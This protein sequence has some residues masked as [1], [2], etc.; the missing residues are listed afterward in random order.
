MSGLR[1]A[2]LHSSPAVYT[3]V[4]IS[5]LPLYRRLLFPSLPQTTQPP[6]IFNHG[7]PELS[8]ATYE[9]LAVIL[10]SHVSPWYTRLT[11]DKT[12]IPE[13]T[14]AI[15]HGLRE[16][17]R[18]TL[19]ADLPLLVYTTLPALLAQHYTDYRAAQL[20]HALSPSTSVAECFHA[21]Q[22]H[23]ALTPESTVVNPEYLRQAV[24]FVLK[25]CMSKEDWEAET[26]R[27]I[28]R[29]VLVGPVLGGVLPRLAQPWFLFAMML[30][31]LGRGKG[32]KASA[33]S[34]S[35]APVTSMRQMLVLLIG[36]LHA[37]TSAL[38]SVV[39]LMQS[40][41]RFLAS[42]PTRKQY[43]SQSRYYASNLLMLV[44]IV[45][46]LP[47]RL[48][49]DL[50]LSYTSII[51]ALLQPLLDRILSHVLYAYILTSVNISTIVIRANTILFPNG[52]PAPPTI[53]PPHEQQ[54]LTRQL[55]EARLVDSLPS[56]LS[57]IIIGPTTEARSRTAHDILQPLSDA[58]CN[59]HLIMRL[60][61][62]ILLSL[63]PELAADSP[64]IP[65]PS[66]PLGSLPE[67]AKVDSD[68]ESN[69][70]GF[71]TP[72]SH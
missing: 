50:L 29:E 26:D 40:I 43:S 39:T 1:P 65:A 58:G 11:R 16:V 33:K 35:K 62:A 30:G 69:K 7:S 6:P 67:E 12:F 70:E 24:E 8:I 25:A 27:T 57:S 64:A 51:V 22:P 68:S 15:A 44:A 34:M 45:L 38:H 55:L 47:S 4:P 72:L 54:V 18:R 9:L 56:A 17:E 31:V 53:E 42:L 36:A 37:L 71:A 49:S 52:V 41:S 60:L 14:S 10:R 32:S 21:L 28:V 48:V 5:T 59:V 2:S 63:F 19:A 66:A 3:P 20:R 13:V 46:D 61:D 23:I